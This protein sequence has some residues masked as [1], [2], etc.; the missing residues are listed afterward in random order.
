VG[1]I[2][3]GRSARLADFAPLASIPGIRLISLQKSHGVEQGTRVSFADKLEYPGPDFDLPPD[4]FVDTAAIMEC[5]DLVITVDT[6]VA[7]LAGALGRPTVVLLKKYGADWRWLHDRED[8]IW[9]NSVRIARQL[10]QGDWMGL[11]VHLAGQLAREQGLAGPA[12]APCPE[13]AVSVGELIDKLTV[14]EIKLQ[15]IPNAEK[16]A[17]IVR[18]YQSLS[19]ALD[20]LE[21]N[22]GKLQPLR[23]EL[24]LLNGQLWE[25]EDEIRACEAGEDFGGRF[26]ALARGVYKANDRR[27]ALKGEINRL[28]GSVMTEEKCYTVY[29]G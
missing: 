3:K 17:H 8:T 1:D 27:A 20:R 2:D 16:L 12:V 24:A 22:Q 7:H 26:V 18:E 25:I 15:R 28:T 29:P 21:I 6:A 4:A 9:Y 23:Q 13:I 19:A 14:L 5:L 10:R 11:I